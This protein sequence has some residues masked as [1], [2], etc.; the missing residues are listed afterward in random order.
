MTKQRTILRS[1]AAFLL[2]ASSSAL[3]MDILGIFFNLG[4]ERHILALAPHAGIGF[5][6]AHGLAFLIGILMCRAQAVRPWHLTGAAVGALLGTAN[7]VFWPIFIATGWLWGGYLTTSLH[8]L[9]FGLQ[10]AAAFAA[11]PGRSTAQLL[12]STRHGNEQGAW[13]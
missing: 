12:T 10:A 5:V 7:L 8:W 3:V 6:E 1:H 9:F 11:K 13:I 2:A 4:P